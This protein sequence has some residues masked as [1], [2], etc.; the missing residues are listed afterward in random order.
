MNPTDPL[1]AIPNYAAWLTTDQVAERVGASSVVVNNWIV[2]GIRTESGRLRL[3]AAKVGGRWKIEPAAVTEFVTAMT[4]ASL[5]PSAT[6]VPG[7]SDRAEGGDGS[8]PEAAGR[9]VHGTPE[10]KGLA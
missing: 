6:A 10:G 3:R 1:A 2:T 5:P 7:G 8:R 9:R 4:V